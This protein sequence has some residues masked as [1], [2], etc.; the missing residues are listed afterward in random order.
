MFP[1]N[2]GVKLHGSKLTHKTI[3]FIV[4]AVRTS[5]LKNFSRIPVTMV[6]VEQTEATGPGVCC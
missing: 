1:Q 6:F 5:H 3:I 2:I 4:I